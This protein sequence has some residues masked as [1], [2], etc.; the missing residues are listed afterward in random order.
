M[1]TGILSLQGN[2]L[3]HTRSLDL[4]KKDYI[5]IK[6]KNDLKSIDSLIL[7]GGESTSMIKYKVT[8]S[9]LKN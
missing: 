9:Y 5:L 3:D 4:I 8:M 6:Q 2:F 7:P 1:T